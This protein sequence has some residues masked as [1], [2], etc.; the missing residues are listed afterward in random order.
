LLTEG[1]TR[2]AFEEAG[3]KALLWRDDTEVAL[4]WFKLLW[5]LMGRAG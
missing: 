3:Y 5:S 4:G 2:T 1:E